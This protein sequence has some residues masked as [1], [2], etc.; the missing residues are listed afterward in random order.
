M[1]YVCVGQDELKPI[2]AVRKLGNT[3]PLSCPWEDNSAQAQ[4][5][6]IPSRFLELVMHI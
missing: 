6:E 3:S 4:D 2:K 5:L 1:E